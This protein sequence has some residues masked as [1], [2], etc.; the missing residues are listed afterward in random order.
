MKAQINLFDEIIVDNFAG[1]GGASTGIELA[2][3][4]PVT[5]AINH[6]P[7]AILMHKTNHPHTLHLQA[8]VWDVDP[9]EVCA[10]RPVGLAWFSPD[11]KHFSKAKGSALVDRNIRG[12]AWIVLRWAGTVR[13]R[14]IILE[15]VEEFTTWGPVRKGKPIKSKQGKTFQKWLSQLEALGYKV[16][17]RE[18]VA[19]DYGAPTTRKRFVLVARCDGKPIVWPARTNAPKD[20]EEVK[21]GKLLPWRAAAEIIDFSLPMYSIFATKEEIKEKYGVTVVRPLAENTQRR[22]IRGVDKYT[23]KSGDPFL[24]P[25][26]Y[27]E[28]AGQAPRVHDINAPLPTV[29]ST[30]KTHLVE[31]LVAPFVAQA[32]FQ[33]A[34]QDIQKPLSTITSVGAHEL[35]EPLLEPYTFSN[36]GG[37]VGAP[38]DQPIGTVRTAGGQVLAAANLMQYHTEQGEENARVNDL[39][40]PLPTVDASNRY[41]LTAAHLTEFYGNGNPLDPKDPMHTVTGHDREALTAVH[42]DKYFAGGY[43][44]AGNGADEPLST[45]TVEPRH[46]LVASHMMEFKGQ[47]VGQGLEQPL[48]TITAGGGEFGLAS[49]RIEKY[50]PE[51]PFSSRWL[52][53]WPEIRALLNKHCG[54]HLADDEIL[55]LRIGGAWYFLSDITMRMLTPKELYAAMGFPPDYIF[56]FIDPSTG[57]PYPKSAQVAR[58]GNAVCPQM[59]SAV[60]RANLPEWAV[61]LQTMA[62]LERMIAV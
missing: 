29:V 45:I 59:A 31:P 34:A 40:D 54:Y 39:D 57:K 26:G 9:E 22:A 47:N 43:K 49:V 21:S 36:T 37:S 11:C 56:D 52:G 42:L 13:P 4:R 15:N 12:L 6:D 7:A 8:S 33:N 23:I 17:Y 3:G 25:V 28:R 35:V 61:E 44:C 62:E 58:C 24:I 32:K 50:D 10:G 1:G 60:V 38:A 18:L 41:G 19:A 5:I 20:S 16:E 53:H 30:V 46:G 51:A 55:L 27:G 2:T 48:R 14:V